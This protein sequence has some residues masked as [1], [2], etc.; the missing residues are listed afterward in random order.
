VLSHL[1]PVS[2]IHLCLTSACFPFNLHQF[3]IFYVLL[4]YLGRNVHRCLGTHICGHAQS[5]G[6]VCSMT[7]NIYH[8]ED[9]VVCYML[10]KEVRTF[11]CLIKT[12][13]VVQL[14]RRAQAC[15]P[16]LLM[17]R[18]RHFD[19]VILSALENVRL[20]LSRY[21]TQHKKA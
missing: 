20:V 3:S 10:E 17:L 12:F 8:R 11:E 6:H 15:D 13:C 19:R 4:R 14:L 1:I 9:H 5:C 2:A 21:L 18:H 16:V 7:D